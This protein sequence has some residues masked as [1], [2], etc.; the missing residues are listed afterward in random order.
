VLKDAFGDRLK[1]LFSPQHGL[2]GDVQDNMI[3]S[4]HFQHPYYNIPVYS[5][6]SETREPTEEMLSGLDV[7]FCDLQD[8]GT[9]VY[10][11]IYSV[12][13][14][15]K[16]C[17]GKDIKVVIL[18]RPNAIDADTIQGNILDPEY[19]S[20]VG[21]HPIPMRHGLTVGEVATMAKEHWGIDCDLEVVRMEDYDRKMSFNETGLPWVIPSPNLPFTDTAYVYPGSVIFEGTNISEG[22]GTTRSLEVVGHPNIEP[23]S[24]CDHLE[25]VFS[26][27]EEEGFILRPVSFIPTFHKYAEQSC[28]GVQIHPT[29]YRR[30]NPWRVG[31]I[32]CR[33]LYH[34]LK[35]DFQWKQPPYEYEYEKLPIDI[36]NGTDTIRKWVELNG[37]YEALIDLENPGMD[38]YLNDREC[39][40][41][42]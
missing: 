5:L 35:D 37:S 42:Y 36:L 20:F 34:F 39:C 41:L 27:T 13:N 4:D 18:D 28:G 21:M 26:K 9:R 32:L 40:L 19:K 14:T 7:I 23:F 10:T 2:V 30:F 1:C 24:F 29:D 6:Y 3:E 38:Q 12:T 8:V 33:E 25:Q 15:M 16:A 22:R 31:Q 11:Y 17:Q